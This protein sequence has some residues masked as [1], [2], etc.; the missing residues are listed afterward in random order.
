MSPLPQ[1]LS[2]EQPGGRPRPVLSAERGDADAE[3]HQQEVVPSSRLAHRSPAS[4]IGC[5]FHLPQ[6]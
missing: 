3:P 2:T 4:R 1:A 5:D 6:T